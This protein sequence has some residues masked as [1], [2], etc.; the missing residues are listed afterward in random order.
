[1]SSAI[2]TLFLSSYHSLFVCVFL[3]F[4]DCVILACSSIAAEN[5]LTNIYA[6]FAHREQSD[7]ERTKTFYRT[8]TTNTDARLCIPMKRFDVIYGKQ[9]RGK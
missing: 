6:S 5:E 4:C 8:A 3:P 7:L 2:F 9:F 1:M